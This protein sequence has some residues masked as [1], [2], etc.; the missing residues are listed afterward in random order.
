MTI[1][2]RNHRRLFNIVSVVTIAI[3]TFVVSLAIRQKEDQNC[4][5]LNAVVTL[6]NGK[7]TIT[8]NDSFDY[9]NTE[10]YINKHYRIIGF[11]LPAGE[12]NDIWQVEFSNNFRHRMKPEKKAITFSIVCELNDGRKGVHYTDFSKSR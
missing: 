12:S 9:V 11:N 7:I 5:L 10:L 4:I 6:D 1:R 2:I 8:N 3:A